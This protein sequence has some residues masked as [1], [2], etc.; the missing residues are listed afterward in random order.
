MSSNEASNIYS[1]VQQRGSIPILWAQNPNFDKTAPFVVS[2]NQQ[3]IKEQM[4][5]YL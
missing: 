2:H 4:K 3:E 5:S 1:F